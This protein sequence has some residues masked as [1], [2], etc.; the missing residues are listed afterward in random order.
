MNTKAFRRTKHSLI[1]AALIIMIFTLYIAISSPRIQAAMGA[2]YDRP[3]YKGNKDGKVAI[4]CAVSWNAAA[5]DKILNELKTNNTNITFLVSGEWA[6]NNND[7]LQRIRSDGHE[8][9]TLGMKPNEDGNISWLLD[10]ISNSV[11]RIESITGIKP[12]L[13]Y[14]GT[15]QR[16]ASSRAAS[17]LELTHVLCTV[18]LLCARGDDSDIAQR[19]LEAA[20]EGN[21][22]LVQPTTGLADALPKILDSFRQQG[23][24]VTVTG[25]VLGM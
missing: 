7:M 16:S 22:I 10:D 14:S 19:A 5:L 18:D 24:E 1:N 3:Y 15:R 6:E 23:I 8:I 2:V 20:N 25:E 9:G 12:K 4:Q 11:E 13:Y 17:E 21:I